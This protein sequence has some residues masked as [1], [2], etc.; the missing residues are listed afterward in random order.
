M[1]PPPGTPLYP[2]DRLGVIGTDDQLQ[3]FKRFIDESCP[4]EEPD[5]TEESS[6]E[7]SLIHVIFGENSPLIGQTIRE[8]ELR[9]KTSGLV[10]GIERDGKR[11]LN[12]NSEMVFQAGDLVWIVGDKAK[13]SQLTSPQIRPIEAT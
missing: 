8:S 6:D 1:A 5:S 2:G 13:I 10:V 12:P 11:H 4:E 9:E 3:N 7:A